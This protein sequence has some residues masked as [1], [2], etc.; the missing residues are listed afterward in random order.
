MII[1]VGLEG[2]LGKRTRRVPRLQP[3]AGATRRRLLY[4]LDRLIRL[5]CRLDDDEPVSVP[6]GVRFDPTLPAAALTCNLLDLHPALPKAA[7]EHDGRAGR[8]AVGVL[9]NRMEDGAVRPL[10]DDET[11]AL[12]HAATIKGQA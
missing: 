10:H 9:E 8:P 2:W 6:H 3:R 4:Q 12:L 11:P 1:G 7:I 5:R